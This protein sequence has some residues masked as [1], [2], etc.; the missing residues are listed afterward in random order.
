MQ[1]RREVKLFLLLTALFCYAFYLYL[2]LAEKPVWNDLLSAS[3]MWC[4]GVAAILTRLILRR[5]VR[6]LGW[7]WGRSHRYLA[8][9]Y[10]I[11]FALCLSVYAAVWLA[12]LGEFSDARLRQAMQRF[13]VTNDLGLLLAPLAFLM[14]VPGVVLSSVT[15]LGEELGWRGLL[16]PAL[17]K[18]CSPLR[19]SLLIGV[20]CSVWHYP[21]IFVL[22]PQHRAGLPVWYATL[23][24]T[25]T[26]VAITFI[27]TW[28]RPRA[29]S[30]WPCVLL[31][32]SSNGAQQFFEILTRNTGSTYYFTYEYGAG[33]VAMMAVLLGVTGRKLTQRSAPG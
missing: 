26:V 20:I 28:L 31:H 27:Y 13:G 4:P 8:G 24:F 1:P 2:F 14:T 3:F 23:C 11:P 25:L 33:F 9:V 22:I 32:A 29:E 30:V 19:T 6:D 21:L 18:I 7:G 15:T 17:L 10:F 12:G 16:T 5:N